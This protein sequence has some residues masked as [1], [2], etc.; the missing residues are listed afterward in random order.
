MIIQSYDC[1]RFSGTGA[2]IGAS[3]IKRQRL[4]VSVGANSDS[5]ILGVGANLES[6]ILGI[7]SPIHP[8]LK[9]GF[10]F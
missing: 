7:A 1:L 10:I 3:V 6:F 2:L 5:F 8:R 4:S 9:E